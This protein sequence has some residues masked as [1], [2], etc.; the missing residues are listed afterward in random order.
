VCQNIRA[1]LK[2]LTKAIEL[3][4]IYLLVEMCRVDILAYRLISGISVHARNGLSYLRI[5]GTDLHKRVVP[6][7]YD[8]RL[9]TS[10]FVLLPQLLALTRLQGFSLVKIHKCAC[11]ISETSGCASNLSRGNRS[12]KV[13][14]NARRIDTVKTCIFRRML[15]ERYSGSTMVQECRP[16]P[17]HASVSY[18]GK[19]FRY[20]PFVGGPC[21]L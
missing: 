9:K 21:T 1:Y 12:Q 15:A 20:G 17:P 13:E 2:I 5:H 8:L 7:G 16:M 4:N 11:A 18:V 19:F 10:S 6:S 3:S 14:S